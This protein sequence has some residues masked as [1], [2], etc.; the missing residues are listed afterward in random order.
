MRS[1]SGVV[2]AKTMRNLADCQEGAAILEFVLVL[3]ILLALLGAAFELGRA[4]LFREAMIEAVRGGA[5]TLAR[6]PDPTCLNICTPGAARAVAMTR[7]AIVENT[8]LLPAA[9]SV[10]AQWEPGSP[11]VTMQAR[12]TLDSDMLRF[13]GLGPLL[14]LSAVHQE[15]RIAE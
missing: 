8:G 13:V 7:N 14:T 4:L 10:A 12:L 15:Q 1:P 6:V 5:R 11:T 3:P 9:I 2:R